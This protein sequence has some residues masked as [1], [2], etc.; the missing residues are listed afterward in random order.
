MIP[1]ALSAAWSGLFAVLRSSVGRAVLIGAVAVS[2][3][4]W[5]GWS[6]RARLDET[7]ALRATVAKLEREARA[8]TDAAIEDQKRANDDLADRLA[9]QEKI[10]A[11]EAR[12]SPG[13][14][15]PD[16]AARRLRDLWGR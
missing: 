16:D 10:D 2:V 11:L 5:Q 14:C 3:G 15:L 4:A 12:P 13:D 9:L 7:A 1:I 8:W 6:L